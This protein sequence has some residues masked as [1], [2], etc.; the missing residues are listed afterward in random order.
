[1]INIPGER[2]HIQPPIVPKE[3]KKSEEAKPEEYKSRPT[4]VPKEGFTHAPELDS[5]AIAVRMAALVQEAKKK[6]LSFQEIIQKAID[7]SGMTNPQAA[8][9]E[10]NRKVQK[11]IDD[12]LVAIKG[13]KELMEEAEAWEEFANMLEN[14]LSEEQVEGFL[15]VIKDTIRSL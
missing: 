6:E 12:I 11:E 5:R 7:E 4:P 14:E 1:M 9:E 3:A 10:A 15:G 2:P 13:N 8:L